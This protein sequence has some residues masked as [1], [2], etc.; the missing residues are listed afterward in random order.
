MQENEF[1]P[2]PN[3]ELLLLG[4]FNWHHYTWEGTANAHLTSPDRLLNPLL[5]LVVNMRLEMVLPKGIPT[6]EARHGSRWTRPDNVWRN[7]DTL[8]TVISCEVRSELHPTNTDHLPIITTLDLGYHPTEATTRFNFRTVDW[9][10]FVKAVSDRIEHSNIPQGQD[11][12]D[13][14]EL[15]SMV[16]KLFQILQEVTTEIVPKIKPLP[17]LKRWWTK[18]LTIKHKEKNCTGANHFKW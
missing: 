6:L 1:M 13:I 2:L 11:I 12:H 14:H 4:D 3:T 16:D 18:D 9:D 10:K 7:A 5:E 17:H 15:E 8:S